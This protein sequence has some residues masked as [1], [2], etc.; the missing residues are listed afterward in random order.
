[1]DD[2]TT[3]LGPIWPA[4]INTSAKENRQARRKHSGMQGRLA[5]GGLHPGL[6]GCEILDLSETGARVETFVQ[7]DLE[8]PETVSVEFCGAYLRARRRWVHGRQLGLEFIIED[9]KYLDDL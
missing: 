1:M 9:M 2:N 8:L 4:P 5:Y 6:V 3:P 7:L